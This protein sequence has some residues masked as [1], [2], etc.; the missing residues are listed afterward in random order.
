MKDTITKNQF[1]DWFRGSDNYKYN[2]S[3]E[4]LNTL[5][6]Y[7]EELEDDTGIEL[8]FDPIAFCCDFSEHGSFKELV[9]DY[10]PDYE[11]VNIGYFEDRTDIIRIAGTEGFIIQRF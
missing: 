5:Y 4:G 8:E 6:D 9:E 11:D 3:Y 1:I 7:L 2:F 10:C